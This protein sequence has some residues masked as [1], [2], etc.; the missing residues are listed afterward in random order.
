MGWMA[1]TL[2]KM[3][4][5]WV[6]V[7]ANPFPSRDFSIAIGIG[8]MAWHLMSLGQWNQLGKGILLPLVH[9]IA[10]SWLYHYF[11][12]TM[13][14]LPVGDIITSSWL[15]HH[16][17]LI[18]SSLPVDDVITSI[19]LYHDFQLMMSSFLVDDVITFSCHFLGLAEHIKLD[20]LI[21]SG[22]SHI[23]RLH[24]KLTNWYSHLVSRMNRAIQSWSMGQA[25]LWKPLAKEMEPI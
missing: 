19:W 20:E 12:L 15:H 23:G 18:I 10:S 25:W 14:S 3:I 6:M 17:Q 1:T 24:W 8:A 16:F 13:S 4:L 9:V 11:Q 5:Y 21:H 2:A 7:S 22:Q